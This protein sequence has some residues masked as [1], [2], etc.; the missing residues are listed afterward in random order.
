MT[1]TLPGMLPIRNLIEDLL[2]RDVGIEL[3]DP[4]VA[5]DV[6]KTVIALY[7]DRGQRLAAVLGMDLPLA[8]YAGA[9]L[10]LMPAGGAEAAIEDGEL[11]PVLAEN[12]HELCNIL[13]TVLN[14][15]EGTHVRLHEVYLPGYPPPPDAR[16]HLLALGRRLDVTL[17]ISRYG[18]GRLSIALA[19]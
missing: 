13:S 1:L 4:I 11:S 12:V 7:V 8:A 5:A 2:G 6:P 14:R 19:G 9:A 16:S 15:E 17:T 10:G 18:A 3:A